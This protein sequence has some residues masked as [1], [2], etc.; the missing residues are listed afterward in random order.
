MRYAEEKPAL[1]NED[2]VVCLLPASL[3][4]GSAAALALR[5]KHF[6]PV[7]V[8]VTT[9]VK[10][11]LTCVESTPLIN[12]LRDHRTRPHPVLYVVK[13]NTGGKIEN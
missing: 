10:F 8:K 12:H 7:V 11:G 9:L 4:E 5:L 6:Y 3:K 2:A 13:K 1:T